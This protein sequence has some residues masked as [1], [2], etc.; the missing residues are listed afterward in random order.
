[1]FLIVGVLSVIFILWMLNTHYRPKVCTTVRVIH[2]QESEF[3]VA[4]KVVSG[5]GS[6]YGWS[7]DEPVSYRRQTNPGVILENAFVCIKFSSLG[8]RV[9]SIYDKRSRTSCLYKCHSVFYRGK[10]A[11][12]FALKGGISVYGGNFLTF[13]TPEHGRYF[14]RE[15]SMESYQE[16]DGPTVAFSVVDDLRSPVIQPDAFEDYE[17]TEGTFRVEHHLRDDSDVLYTSISAS[18][19]QAVER[20]SLWYATT[21][22]CGSTIGDLPSFTQDARMILAPGVHTTYEHDSWSWMKD[23]PQ[24]FDVSEIEYVAQWLDMGIA[25]IRSKWMGMYDRNQIHAF[26]CDQDLYWKVWS[27]GKPSLTS[28]ENS[29]YQP[30]FEPWCSPV[31]RTF[32]QDG[33]GVSFRTEPGM[34]VEWRL[35]EFTIH[36][37]PSGCSQFEMQ[38]LVQA[39]LDSMS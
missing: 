15:F 36:D 23:K 6:T 37:V 33:D 35:K 9:L 20:T 27:F 14:D 38:R 10:D 7:N 19:P 30:Y 2:E 21:I 31:N 16:S 8:G 12:I 3:R 28:A 34:M 26:V 4:N 5:N 17:T 22:T 29:I 11:S 32:A 25:Y 39:R 24:R 13:P 18:Y 1:M